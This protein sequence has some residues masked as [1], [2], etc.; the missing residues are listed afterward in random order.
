MVKKKNLSL[1]IIL[2]I[3]IAIAGIILAFKIINAKQESNLQEA[4]NNSNE[5][6]EEEDDTLVIRN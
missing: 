6:E 1:I 4:I 3:L 5:V 2:L